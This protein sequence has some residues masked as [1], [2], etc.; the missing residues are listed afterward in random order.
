MVFERVFIA[1][2]AITIFVL[3]NTFSNEIENLN[4]YSVKDIKPYQH[5]ATPKKAD[6]KFANFSPIEKESSKHL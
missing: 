4:P 3:S 6:D 5:N 2:F 1:I